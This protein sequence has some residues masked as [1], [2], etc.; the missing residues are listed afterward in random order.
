[1]HLRLGLPQF[2]F[3][4]GDRM[5]LSLMIHALNSVDKSTALEVNLGWW[6]QVCSNGMKVRVKGS[7][8]RRIHLV[9]R[10][11]VSQ[12]AEVLK[13]QLAVVPAEHSRYR[14]W[15]DTPVAMERIERW[16]DARVARVWGPHA[17]ARLCHIARTGWDGRVENPFETAKPHERQVAS[18]RQVPGAF[19]PVKNAFHV[20]QALSWLAS[21]RRMLEDQFERTPHVHRL[22]SSLLGGW[23]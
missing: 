13:A 12:V 8:T 1:M 3:D 5:P 15:L 18:E 11:G 4:P 16:A 20:S 2:D 6:R 21:H 14:R 10:V 23:T 19:A 9:G 22:M 7:T 17:A